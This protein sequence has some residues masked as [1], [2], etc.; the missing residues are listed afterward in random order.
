MAGYVKIMV[1]YAAVCVLVEELRGEGF[2]IT[3]EI[4]HLFFGLLGGSHIHVLYRDRAAL[5]KL[6]AEYHFDL[7]LLL[8]DLRVH[9]VH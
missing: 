6:A 4:P 9:T 7:L 1:A 8:F 2:R 5:L 3:A